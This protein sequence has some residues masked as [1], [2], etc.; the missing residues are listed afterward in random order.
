MQHWIEYRDLRMKLLVER[1]NAHTERINVVRAKAVK[2][3][4]YTS[5]IV[6]WIY[7]SK[8]SRSPVGFVTYDEDRGIHIWSDAKTRGAYLVTS[9][10]VI[11]KI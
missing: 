7:L 6:G 11:K 2:Q 8:T 9:E 10:G 5:G 1:K 4:G 3:I